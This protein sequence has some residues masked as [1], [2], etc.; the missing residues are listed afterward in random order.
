MLA[1]RYLPLCFQFFRGAEAA[2]SLALFEQLLRV[3][4]IDIEALALTV[5]CIRTANL[6][7]L[8]PLQAEPAQVF[9]QLG[10]IANLAPLHISVFNPKH[11][12]S[13]IV[14]GK[15]PVVE[16]GA[17]IAHVQHTGRRGSK[18]HPRGRVCHKP[19]LMLSS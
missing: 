19:A 18:A 6:R 3:P 15:E 8:R 7:A 13:A 5:G 16:R 11:E 4:L 9:D 14:A 10:F 2:V 12:C 17:G 1:E